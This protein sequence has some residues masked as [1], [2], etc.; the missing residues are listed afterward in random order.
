MWKTDLIMSYPPPTEILFF[1]WCDDRV[2]F[3]LP[4]GIVSP[5][6][7]TYT[8]ELLGEDDFAHSWEAPGKPATPPEAHSMKST[9]HFIKKYAKYF[10]DPLK[11]KNDHNPSDR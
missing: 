7:V 4:A 8:I 2:T 3:D 1:L 11:K 9:M 10:N 6:P 5:D